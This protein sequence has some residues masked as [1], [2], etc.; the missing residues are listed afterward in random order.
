VTSVPTPA[1]AH[2]P[3]VEAAAFPEEA[4]VCREFAPRIRAIALRRLRD[5]AAADDVVQDVL[6][7]VV[8]ALRERRI[9]HP[10]SVPAYVLSACRRRIADVHRGAARRTVLREQLGALEGS[11][12]VDGLQEL[13][14]DMSRVV[15]ALYPLSGREREVI[16]ETFNGGRSA[17]EIARSI[18]TS[19]GN[20][21]LVRHRALAKMRAALG[22]KG[23][24]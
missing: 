4:Q 12:A 19:P 24:V 6:A 15:S 11:R 9:A 20:V 8:I 2:D 3:C 16:N 22:W 10:E 13:H 23:E 1:G 5:A 17:E 7:S 14:L 21:R 18:G